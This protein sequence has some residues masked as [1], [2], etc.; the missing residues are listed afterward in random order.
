MLGVVNTSGLFT[1]PC[2]NH[3]TPIAVRMMVLGVLYFIPLKMSD[4]NIPK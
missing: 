1:N 3:E 4:S 2:A